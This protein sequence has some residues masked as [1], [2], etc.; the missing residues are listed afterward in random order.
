MKGGFED[1]FEQDEQA[2]CV[3]GMWGVVENDMT[4]RVESRDGQEEEG[5]CRGLID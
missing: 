1:H 4:W 5:R 2:D 3:F